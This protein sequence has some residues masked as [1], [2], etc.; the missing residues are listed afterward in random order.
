MF[1]TRSSNTR[2]NQLWKRYEQVAFYDPGLGT[3]AMAT[4]LTKA[5]RTIQ[6]LLASVTGLAP[7]S[8]RLPETS[9]M[10]RC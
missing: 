8:G 2:F 5:Y 7:G 9:Q 10:R 3:D 4:G 1:G 6:K